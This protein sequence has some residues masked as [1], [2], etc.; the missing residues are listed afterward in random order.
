MKGGPQFMS[1][2]FDCPFI[3]I[4]VR[5]ILIEQALKTELLFNFYFFKQTTA[6]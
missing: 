1:V 6:S 4:D 5:N 2:P 3:K